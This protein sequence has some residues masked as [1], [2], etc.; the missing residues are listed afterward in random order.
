MNLHHSR[1]DFKQYEME[2]RFLNEQKARHI[3]REEKRN[4]FLEQLE[5]EKTEAEAAKQ[6]MKEPMS[7]DQLEEVWDKVDQLPKDEWD[8]NRWLSSFGET[9]RSQGDPSGQIVGLS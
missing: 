4:E 9:R 1:N 3:K 5:K 6:R 2:R 8:Q 7:K